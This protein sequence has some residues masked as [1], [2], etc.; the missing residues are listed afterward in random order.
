[1]IP[2][3]DRSIADD[4]HVEALLA[5]DEAL[6]AGADPSAFDGPSS[7][8]H[9]VHECQRLLEA[10]WPRSVPTSPDLPRRF[11]RFSIVREVGRGGFGVVFLAVDPDLRRQVALKVPRP[12]VMVAA[13]IRRR[14]LR[15]AEAA[16]RLD[17]PHIVPVYEV[18]EEG[19]ICYIA[20]AYCEGPTLAEWRRGRTTPVPWI[21]AAR[22]VAVLAAAVAHAHE[23][24]ILH[25]DLKPGNILL[26][27]RE[28]SDPANEADC[29][30]L[31][32]YVPRICDFGLAKLLDEVSQETC[33]GLAIGSPPY[34][35][36]EQAAG[37]TREQGPATDVYAL[38]VILY[39]LLTGR[40]PLRGETDL[41]T[42]RLISDQDPPSPRAL[43][44][45]LPRDL[46]TICLKCLEKRP[47][48][49]YA[50][51]SE[52]AEDLGGSSTDA[53]SEP[54]RCT[55]LGARR[56]V[57]EAT[58]RPCGAGGRGRDGRARRPRRPRVGPGAR[59]AVS[60]AL[61][62]PL[63]RSRRSEAEARD[64]RRPGRPASDGR[65]S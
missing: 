43:R 17:H 48:R 50:G 5:F 52:L 32:S 4:S 21:E 41:E 26:Q 8:L 45:G 13:S 19:P 27:P 20:S 54:G 65:T 3:I 12:E 16:S 47:D 46:E 6:V 42:L 2:D 35:A 44:P 25:R 64:Q 58:A 36:P 49:R 59:A 33:S 14:F 28:A 55:A 30:D 39:E 60:R 38:G 53:R 62:R 61:A 9:A 23:R 7:P 34:M 51:A 57:G 1:M 24:G 63:E 29:E 22:L 18:G 15:E 40:P 10:V 37:R 31:A 11:G 56:Q